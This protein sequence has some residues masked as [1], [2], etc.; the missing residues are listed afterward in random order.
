MQPEPLSALIVPKVD[1]VRYCYII[2]GYVFV[3]EE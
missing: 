3:R 1:K 2:D